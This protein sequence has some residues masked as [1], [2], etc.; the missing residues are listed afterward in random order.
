MNSFFDD[1]TD[2]QT[3]GGVQGAQAGLI[4]D[5]LKSVAAT[6]TPSAGFPAAPM[7]ANA[8][9]PAPAPQPQQASPID[10]GGYQMPRIGPAAAFTPPQ[11]NR[12]G[13][14]AACRSA[15]AATR[16]TAGRSRCANIS[17]HRTQPSGH[18]GG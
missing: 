10:V 9:I 17:G 16:G 3:F 15:F 8:A 7:D 14:S 13:H 4:D 12:S 5:L 18:R 2:P 6:P 1:Y 11:I